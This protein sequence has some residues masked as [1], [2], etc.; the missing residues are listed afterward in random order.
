MLLRFLEKN[1]PHLVVTDT[2]HERHEVAIDSS[3]KGMSMG[4]TRVK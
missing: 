2:A 1:E 4:E 3:A